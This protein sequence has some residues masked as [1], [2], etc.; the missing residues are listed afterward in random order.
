MPQIVVVYHLATA[1][2][3][4][5]QQVADGAM[6]S[7]WRLTPMATCPTAAG[8][9]STPQMPSSSA[10]HLHGRPQLA[11]Q[12]VCRCVI[13]SVV[14]PRLGKT[15]CLVVLPTAPAPAATSRSR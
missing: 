6:P 3:S 11:V 15:R 7:C 2:P 10:P 9:R 4:V 12:E 5:A 13:Q 14:F 8:K 1:T